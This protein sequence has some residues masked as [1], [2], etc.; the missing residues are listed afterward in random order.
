MTIAITSG[1][2]DVGMY[3]FSMLLLYLMLHFIFSLVPHVL[4]HIS[5]AS[6]AE[7]K[8]VQRV[9]VYCSDVICFRHICANGL[10]MF[11]YKGFSCLNSLNCSL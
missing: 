3:L 2:C 8:E 9:V 10:K 11:G 5:R 6:L 7:K 4:R 1:V